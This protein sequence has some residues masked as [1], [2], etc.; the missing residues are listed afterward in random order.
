MEV[1][2]IITMISNFGGFIDFIKQLDFD[3]IVQMFVQ[4]IMNFVT[5]MVWPRLLDEAYRNGT[6]LDLVSDG[7]C[8]ILGRT[9]TGPGIDTTPFTVCNLTLKTLWVGVL[10]GDMGNTLPGFLLA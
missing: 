3:V 10:S 8:R 2:E 7:L 6:G 1:L 9:E 5:A 4:A